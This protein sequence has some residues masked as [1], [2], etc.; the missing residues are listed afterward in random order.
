M[1]EHS[2]QG[3]EERSVIETVLSWI[4]KVVLPH[5]SVSQL[6]G[7]KRTGVV[8]KRKIGFTS[9]NYSWTQRYLKSCT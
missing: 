4:G 7:R 6:A 2:R 8:L 5:Q 9:G 1:G 3:K